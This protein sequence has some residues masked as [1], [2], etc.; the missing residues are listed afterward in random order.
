[1]ENGEKKSVWRHA[2]NHQILS[3]LA[4][5]LTLMIVGGIDR[6][7]QLQLWSADMN[8][9][10]FVDIISF[11]AMALIQ[12]HYRTRILMQG[13]KSASVQILGYSIFVSVVANLIIHFG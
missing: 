8:R 10:L 7:L 6:L 3:T 1:M 4:A 9:L 13:W 11:S 5:F 2:N 12:M